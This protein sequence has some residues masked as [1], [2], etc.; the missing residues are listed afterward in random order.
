M[1]LT[2]GLLFYLGTFWVVGYSVIVTM[3]DGLHPPKSTATS[4][5]A[6]PSQRGQR[7]QHPQKGT[8]WFRDQTSSRKKN[9]EAGVSEQ[10][11]GP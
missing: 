11:T 7:D 10:I 9:S 3:T 4:M 6:D 2:K 1:D 5:A 8:L